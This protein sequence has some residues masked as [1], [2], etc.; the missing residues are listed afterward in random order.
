MAERLT[1]SVDRNV[2]V[3]MRDGV[4]LFADVYRPS[5]PGPYP[6]LLQ[7]TPYDKQ[8]GRRIAASSC[9]RRGE[10]L[11]RRRAGCARAVRVRGGVH[12]FVN[13]RQD[14][15]DT[16]DWLAAQPW[17]DGDVGMFGGSYVG[18]T[19]WQAAISGHPALKAIAPTSPPP[20]ITTAGP[21]RAARS[22]SASTSPGRW[23]ALAHQHRP[24]QAQGTTPPP[25]RPFRRSSPART[26]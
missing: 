25:R 6:A 20:I 15:Y 9:G 14:G 17:C 1:L 19:Q 2:P 3:P 12:A 21:I 16:L 5:G 7:R 8:N 13:E 26:T 24:A 23:R 22:S 10:R 18:L 4:V 11:R